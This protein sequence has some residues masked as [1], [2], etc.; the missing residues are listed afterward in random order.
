M[1]GPRG[2]AHTRKATI[3]K[4]KD[5]KKRTAAAEGEQEASTA[6]AEAS[7]APARRRGGR[8]KTKTAVAAVAGT[9]DTVLATMVEDIMKEG[10]ELG[11]DAARENA[12]DLLALVFDTGD[13]REGKGERSLFSRLLIL[14]AAKWP[15]TVVACLSLV[16]EYASWRTLNLIADE[17]AAVETEDP[18]F[19]RTLKCIQEEVARLYQAQLLADQAAMA[20]SNTSGGGASAGAGAGAG[21]GTSAAASVARISL[22]GK[23]APSEGSRFQRS[24]GRLATRIRLLLF[25]LNVAPHVVVAASGGDPD[26]MARLNKAKNFSKMQY[27][28]LVSSLRRHLQVVETFMCSGSWDKI[29][30]TSVPSVANMKY[31]KAFMNVPLVPKKDCPVRSTDP[32]RIACAEAFKVAIAETIAGAPGTKKLKG[33]V[34]Q[35]HELVAGFLNR[36]YSSPEEK[37]MVEALWAALTASVREKGTLT[38]TIALVD[39]SGSMAGL[40]M[41]VSIALGLMIADLSPEPWHNRMITFHESPSWCQIPNT[42][43][44]LEEKVRL[45]AAMPWGGSTAFDQALKLVL[46]TALTQRTPAHEMPKT[47]IVLTDMQFDAACGGRGT[48]A[49][50]TAIDRVKQAYMNAGYTAPHIVVW[51]LRATGRPV[52]VAEADTPGVSFMSGFSSA[53]LKDF[54]ENGVLASGPEEPTVTPWEMLSARLQRPRLDAVRAVAA[55]VQEGPMAGYTMPVREAAADK[56]GDESM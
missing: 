36:S 20:A 46:D 6:S 21:A 23:W 26:S 42:V 16:P 52:F 55:R 27:R 25:P 19:S 54:M 41:T 9:A 2:A 51:N 33:A 44:T 29:V 28:R 31:K 11:P 43:T 34:N 48:T 10:E 24:K 18:E 32:R 49:P 53:V 22:A 14:L 40:P 47:M 15:A 1:I 17:A 50:L 45:A 38:T 37:S 13:V 12:A 35:P 7:T 39:V 30:P 3:V 56:S 5:K 8:R 4:A